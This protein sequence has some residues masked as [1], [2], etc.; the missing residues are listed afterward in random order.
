[1]VRIRK[2]RIQ[3]ASKVKAL[4]GF[5]TVTATEEYLRG[6]SVYSDADFKFLSINNYISDHS[7]ILSLRGNYNQESIDALLHYFFFEKH[8]Y[9]VSA[10]LPLDDHATEEALVNNGF[11]QEAVLHEELLTDGSFTD[12]GLFYI[13][14]PMYRRYNVGFIPFQRGV[15][16]VCGGIDYVDDITFLRFEDTPKSDYL[17]LCADYCGFIKDGK[18]KPRG[19]VCYKDQFFDDLPAEVMRAVKQIREYL[20][21]ERTSFDINVRL[22]ETSDFRLSVWK[23]IRNIPYGYTRSY[24]DIALELT[25]GDVK[26]AQRLTRAV[27]HACSENPVPVIVPCHRVIGKDGKLVGF[28]DGVEFKDFLLTHELFAAMPL[29]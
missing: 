21:K 4:L 15:I 10:I 16:A 6:R 28:K 17:R 20:Y 22:P 11:L 1:M 29:A 19:D 12:A 23:C 24:E 7:V 2:V 25:K 14:M 8:I 3:D 5:D 9:K 27:G 18:L 13:T 26:K